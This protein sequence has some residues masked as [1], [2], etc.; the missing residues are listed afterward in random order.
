MLE[1]KNWK[2]SELEIIKE[3]LG[4]L[5]E[6][7]TTFS[8][9]IKALVREDYLSRA[10]KSYLSVA[11]MY[12][13]STGSIVLYNPAFGGLLKLGEVEVPILDFTLVTLVGFSLFTHLQVKKFWAALMYPQFNKG[14][15]ATPRIKLVDTEMI[16]EE[17]DYRGNVLYLNPANVSL[18]RSFAL[19]YTSFLIA[20]DPLLRAFPDAYHFLKKTVFAGHDY[21]D[22][23]LS[24][25]FGKTRLKV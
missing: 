1:E 21:R 3:I 13:V 22:K 15:G 7:H 14:R 10:G 5:P 25:G 4:F 16:R 12:R 20:P 24:T 18:D 8:E 2:V 23:A 17:I 19:A 6:R 9:V 11:G